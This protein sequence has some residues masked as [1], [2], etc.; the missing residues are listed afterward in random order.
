[1]SALFASTHSRSAAI[2]SSLE[3]YGSTSES[4]QNL[5]VT[6]ST[7]D[8]SNGVSVAQSVRRP[9]E[10]P[11]NL[12]RLL[13]RERQRTATLQRVLTARTGISQPNIS[14]YEQGRRE[15]TWPVFVR[16]IEAMDRR[17]VVST[18]PLES[19]ADR[20]RSVISINSVVH[21]VLEV[22]GDRLYRFEHNAAAHIL[23][24]DLPLDFV[25]V[26]VLGD[27]NNLDELAL[28]AT[29]R[30][31]RREVRTLRGGTLRPQIKF[32]AAL[33]AIAIEVT[34]APRDHVLVTVDG[35]QV[36]VAPMEDVRV[37]PLL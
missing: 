17:L 25:H 27:P 30:D 24:L 3:C 9:D 34:D 14:A 11:P 26:S 35:K 15:P 12:G 36:R 8:P 16:L 32:E 37:Q 23:G 6:T 33:A 19:A 2:H 10:G 5:L 1:V 18:E 20:I 7:D 22:V 13:Y 29:G 28:R 21:E 4:S 31:G